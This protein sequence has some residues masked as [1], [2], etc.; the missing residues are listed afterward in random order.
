MN[1]WV[2]LFLLIGM[3]LPTALQANQLVHFCMMEMASHHEMMGN[4]HDCC[5]SD[6]SQQSNVPEDHQCETLSI[7]NCSFGETP[8]NDPATIVS[9]STALILSQTGFSFL[10][11]PPDPF[12]HKELFSYNNPEAPPLYRLYDTFLN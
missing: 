4:S 7:C 11:T 5:L 10:I 12:V 1:K 2:A 6:T 9:G 8:F 3:L